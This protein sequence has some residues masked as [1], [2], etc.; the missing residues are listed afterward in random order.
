[1]R[2]LHGRDQRDADEHGLP[3]HAGARD[4]AAAAAGVGQALLWLRGTA[5]HRW[6]DRWVTDYISE[7]ERTFIA[8][9]SY[10]PFRSIKKKKTV[11]R[12]SRKHSLVESTTH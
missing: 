10:F 5:R 4:G 9:Q 1:M 3:A 12:F 7:R 8:I 6:R 2:S 11:G